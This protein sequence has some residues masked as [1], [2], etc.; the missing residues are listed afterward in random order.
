[1]P[2]RIFRADPE[3]GA[4]GHGDEHRRE[5]NRPFP[6]EQLPKDQRLEKAQPLLGG[7]IPAQAK[8]YVL[9]TNPRRAV[10]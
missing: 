8:D 3:Q 1:M 4:L 10:G 5:S 2:N 6:P 9:R 7:D